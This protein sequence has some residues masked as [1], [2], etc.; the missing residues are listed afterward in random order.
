MTINIC[1]KIIIFLIFSILIIISDDSALV[2]GKDIEKIVYT[3]EYD[4]QETI[5]EELFGEESEYEEYDVYT[6]IDEEPENTNEMIVL[7]PPVENKYQPVLKATVEKIYSFRSI[8]SFNT[9]WDNSDNFR[10]L[11]RTVP[12][13]MQTAPSIIH[14][15][16]YKFKPDDN[17]SVD[18]GHSALSSFDGLSVGFI[19]KLESDY[20]S[21]MKITTK[22]GK[23]NISSAIY[24][25]LET[26]NPAGGML[27]STN[28]FSLGEMKGKI[29][30]GGG[31]YTNEYGNTNASKNSYGL[32][33]QYKKG[34]FT[35]GAQ[36][37]KTQ[38]SNENYGTSIYLYPKIR[39]TNSLT[40]TSKI[41]NHFEQ[42]YNQEEIGLT[43]KPAR[44]NP[45]D[46]SISINAS[47]YN[48]EG[49]K[50]KQRLKLSTEFKL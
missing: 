43:Y 33:T 1:K 7:A 23:L 12:S 35:L 50:N 36:I 31:I 44:N 45:N 14:A 49:T 3:E 46:F 10:T 24:D 5:D 41:A 34:R 38:F 2:F 28:D 19:E 18:W 6:E 25:S 26:N 15:A 21:G 27:I 47:L 32:F 16:H 29:R 13:M 48:G 37:G 42:N 17:T 11:Y 20:D 39:L 8:D 40:I 30:F 22:I 4:S 9:I